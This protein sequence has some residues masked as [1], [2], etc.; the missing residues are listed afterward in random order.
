M[1]V[2][3]LAVQHERIEVLAIDLRRLDQRQLGRHGA[4][5]PYF[6]DQT[7]VVRQLADARGL[8]R[9]AHAVHGREDRVDRDRAQRLVL[10]EVVLGRHVAAPLLDRHLEME[11]AVHRQRGDVHLG[12][13]DARVAFADHVGA[14]D[15]ALAR[16]VDLALEL[17]LA[18]VLDAQALQVEDHVG[19]VL[20]HAFQRVEL[21]VRALDLHRR[22]RGALDRR[23]QHA[24]Q[25]VADRVAEAALEGLDDEAAVQGRQGFGIGLH[26]A[27]QLEI[28][29][30][31]SHGG[32][33]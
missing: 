12:V 1:L 4:V 3:A 14:G 8:D 6:Q 9:V 26:L 22:D 11:L 27:R 23:E 31:D 17:V 16:L 5:G 7:I 33:S 24:P 25:A 15:R 18:L 28:A 29:P 19:D 2:A 30:A 21:V 13:G 20:V 32:S 10:R